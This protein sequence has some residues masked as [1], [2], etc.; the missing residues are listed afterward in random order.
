[1]P[2]HAYLV[3]IS[4]RSVADESTPIRALQE[5]RIAGAGLDVLSR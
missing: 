1:M 3:N 5:G 4:R 2:A